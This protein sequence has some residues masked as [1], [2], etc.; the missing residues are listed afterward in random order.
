MNPLGWGIS[1]FGSNWTCCA[2]KAINQQFS[3]G[4]DRGG[5][6]KKKRSVQNK[7]EIS[8]IMQIRKSWKEF[9]DGFRTAYK[10]YI[11]WKL[12]RKFR[13]EKQ[14]EIFWKMY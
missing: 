5:V 10:G 3:H 9:V 13:N 8:A 7:F 11:E 12:E 1:G 2:V 4:V 14:Q 6:Q